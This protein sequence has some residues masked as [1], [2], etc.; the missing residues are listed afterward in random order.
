MESLKFTTLIPC[1]SSSGNLARPKLAANHHDVISQV[2]FAPLWNR[3]SKTEALRLRATFSSKAGSQ[4][5]ASVVEDQKEEEKGVR[6]G[7][8]RDSSGSVIGFNLSPPNGKSLIVFET[9]IVVHF[10][11]Y[12][13]F[14]VMNVERLRILMVSFPKFSSKNRFLR[15]DVF[16]EP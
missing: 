5:G 15:T 11:I 16:S 13:I 2:G 9:L 10:R 14:V 6:F 1:K 8:E 12:T 7:A 4:D 3:R